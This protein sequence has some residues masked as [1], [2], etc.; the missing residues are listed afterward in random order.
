MR[1]MA[2]FF[3][4]PITS[5][6][7]ENSKYRG[8]IAWS[9]GLHPFSL[10]NCISKKLKKQTNKIIKAMHAHSFKSQEILKCFVSTRQ[11]L[12]LPL[13]LHQK[14]VAVWYLEI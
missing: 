1:K 9:N 3:P 13:T 12:G 4:C 2:I 7:V 6:G 8:Y 11:S 14:P 5:S 10:Y